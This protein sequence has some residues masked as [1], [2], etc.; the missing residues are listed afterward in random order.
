MLIRLH[1]ND[2]FHCL[3]SQNPN[4]TNVHLD[5]GEPSKIIAIEIDQD[6][7]RQMGVS[8]SDLAKFLN[9]SVTGT[10]M[11]QYR[12]KRELIEIRL[13]G[14]KT[15]RAEKSRARAHRLCVLHQLGAKTAFGC[16]GRLGK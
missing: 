13:R 6:R 4:T 2:N 11:N 7:A 10:V 3:D 8:S 15:E 9:A 12:E 16:P 1:D 14:D 5:W